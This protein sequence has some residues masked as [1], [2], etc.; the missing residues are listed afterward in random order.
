MRIVL[1]TVPDQAAGE[2]LAEKLVGSG[3]SACVQVLARMTSV[4]VWEGKSQKEGEYLL[5]IKTLP[6]KWEEVRDFITANH[7]YEVPEI[8]AIDAARVSEPYLD[9][10]TSALEPK[11]L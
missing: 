9:W 5:L 4:Y 3:L 1:T 2:S 10:L 8:V 7:P 6:E 11:D